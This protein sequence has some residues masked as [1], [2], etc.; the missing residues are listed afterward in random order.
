M[1]LLWGILLY[2]HFKNTIDHSLIVIPG[3]TRNPVFRAELPLSRE[4]RLR[5]CYQDVLGILH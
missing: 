5:N 1:L 3:L 2:A 4:G